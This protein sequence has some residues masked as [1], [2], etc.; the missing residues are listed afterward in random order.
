MR[1]H[2]AVH[3]DQAAGDAVRELGDGLE[4]G[5]QR[6]RG[7]HLGAGV[8]RRPHVRLPPGTGEDDR[9]RH[10]ERRE[11]AGEPPEQRAAVPRQQRGRTVVGRRAVASSTT[12]PTDVPPRL[13]GG[14]AAG[15]GEAARLSLNPLVKAV[16]A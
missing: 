16:G 2:V 8:E 12:T 5:G 10:A 11:L 7:A 14:A 3:D 6:G 15:D 1:D 9:A 4:V 13:A